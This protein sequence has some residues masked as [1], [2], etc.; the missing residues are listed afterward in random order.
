[1]K[2][3]ERGLLIGGE[4]SG[5]I[6]VKDK[7]G[8]GDG[9][10]NALH[11]ASIC[12]EKHKKLSEF[13]DFEPYFQCNINV[14]VSNKMGVINSEKLAIE[15][16]KQE[17]ILAGKGRIMIRVSGTEPYIRVMVECQDKDLS[18]KIA[19]ELAEVVKQIN[20]EFEQCAE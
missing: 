5:H 11:I 8:T 15:T 14:A 7:L 4:Q 13:F 9:I 12:A 2:L 3:A 6:F 10:L 17:T 20:L 18:L 19:N 16:D 1:M